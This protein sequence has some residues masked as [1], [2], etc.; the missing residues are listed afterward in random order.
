MVN[1]SHTDICI[2][3]LQNI[4]YNITMILLNNTIYY[5]CGTI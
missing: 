5:K 3:I 1:K 4:K 2:E